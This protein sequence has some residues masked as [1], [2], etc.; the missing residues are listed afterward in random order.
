MILSWEKRLALQHLSEDAPRTPDI[1]LDIVFLP[2]KHDLRRSVVS[3]R[4]ISSHLGVLQTRK[5]EI[6]DLEVAIFVHEDVAGLEIAMDDACGV[7]ILKT[8]LRH[9]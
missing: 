5:T 8:A 7:D 3:C 9:S 2:C 6:A 1:N 4:D